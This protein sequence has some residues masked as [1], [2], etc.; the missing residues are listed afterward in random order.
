MRLFDDQEKEAH[1]LYFPAVISYY[2]REYASG[3][4]IQIVLISRY[5][6]GV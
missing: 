5:S 6:P 4:S 2:A 3:I 1:L